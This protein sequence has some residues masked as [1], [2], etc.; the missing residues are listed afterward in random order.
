MQF[1]DGHTGQSRNWMMKYFFHLMNKSHLI[2]VAWFKGTQE[3]TVFTFVHIHQMYGAIN[4]A[5][6]KYFCIRHPSDSSGPYY[7]M[8]GLFL[9][10]G[11]VDIVEYII[12]PRQRYKRTIASLAYAISIS[13]AE[14]WRWNM[15]DNFTLPW[16]RVHRGSLVRHVGY[17]DQLI[18]YNEPV[19]ETP[20]AIRMLPGGDSLPRYIENMYI[21][22]FKNSVVSQDEY[23]IISSFY[24]I[25]H[26][27]IVQL[28]KLWDGKI[29]IYA[30]YC[31]F[32]VLFD[33][34]LWGWWKFK[35][36]CSWQNVYC[37]GVVL[38][39]ANCQWEAFEMI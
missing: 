17:N 4:R 32:R 28:C 18:C 29:R 10:C 33:W 26:F 31:V 5:H 35:V 11:Y 2:T 36:P 27:I 20:I 3:M 14:L 25:T 7:A 38:V 39:Q 13:N 8:T 6:N 9:A 34:L 37:V 30:K 21:F 12:H 24:G 15:F 19:G 23:L 22:H 16:P 1:I